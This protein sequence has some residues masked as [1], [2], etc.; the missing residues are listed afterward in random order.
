M[1]R[2]DRRAK[3]RNKEKTKSLKGLEKAKGINVIGIIFFIIFGLLT[4]GPIVIS[5]LTK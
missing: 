5:L 4:I 1:N 3:K 2:A